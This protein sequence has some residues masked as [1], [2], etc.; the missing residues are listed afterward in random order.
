MSNGDSLSAN[1]L[2]ITEIDKVP[3]MY[4][5][6]TKLNLSHNK[7]SALN[8]IFQFSHLTHFDI[9]HN[10]IQNIDE[11][12]K[13]ANRE[14]LLVLCLEG[15]P[16]YRHPDLVPLVLMICPRLVEVNGT[17]ITDHTRQ[18]ISDGILLSERI[19][20]YLCNNEQ[21]LEMLNRDVKRLK[22][23]YE[24]LECSKDW[25][26][27]ENGPFWEDINNRHSRDLKNMIKIPKLPNFT[28]H[29]KIRPYMIIDYV[30]TVGKMHQFFDIG[31]NDTSSLK[32]L[33][34]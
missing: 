14:K 3:G 29:S 12:L 1:F 28:Y 25:I 23:E 31:K 10:L 21:I 27:C 13:I 7:I 26:L 17:K 32:R 2:S 6:I 24:L 19:L 9:S 16:C 11:F 34:K 30:S 18:D 33:Y 22:I 8:M 5:K 4:L 15:N 20:T